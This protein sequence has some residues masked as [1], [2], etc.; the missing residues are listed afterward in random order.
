MQKMLPTKLLQQL[1]MMD[2]IR[3]A[4]CAVIQQTLQEVMQNFKR[5]L[6]LQLDQLRS[7]FN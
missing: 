5:R 7:C 6:A 3:R 4:C 1:E 2:R